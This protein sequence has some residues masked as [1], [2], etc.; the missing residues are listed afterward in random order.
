MS[1]KRLGASNG[2]H[3]QLIHPAAE[4]CGEDFALSFLTLAPASGQDKE[5]VS[6][7][8]LPHSPGERGVER[9]G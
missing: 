8:D 2:Y 5:A 1:K 9:V 3:D 7:G 4:E 6:A